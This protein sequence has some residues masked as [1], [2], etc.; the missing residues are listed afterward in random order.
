MTSL[1]TYDL[2]DKS[3]GSVKT[4]SPLFATELNGGLIQFVVRLFQ[5]R[6]MAK[7]A[8]AKTRAEVSGG[9]RKPW[10]QKGTGQARQGTINAPQWVGGGK[11]FGPKN[12]KRHV[13][14]NRKIHRQTIMMALTSQAEQTVIIKNDDQFDAKVS[15]VR[16]FVDILKAN[17]AI[18]KKVLYVTTTLKSR[19][20]KLGNIE[21]LTISS[22][23]G[24]SVFSILNAHK[25]L[26]EESSFKQLQEM[27]HV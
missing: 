27:Y 14:V 18:D 9:G 2:V 6:G 5:R 20:S 10:K 25:V 23:N 11:A 12:L 15:K 24:L 1:K 16:E 26:I 19:E 8:T 22:V 7:T 13:K 21:G 3:A 4:A 17:N